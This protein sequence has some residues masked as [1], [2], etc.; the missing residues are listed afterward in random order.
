MPKHDI[1]Q[2]IKKY[3][4]IIIHRHVR[5]D[6]DALGSQC[7]LKAIIQ[8]TF[9]GKRV[10]AVGE[11]DESFHFL[12]RMDDIS[13][14]VYEGALVIVCDTA[15]TGRIS[16]SRYDLGEQLIKIDH[17]PDHDEYG[18]IRWVNTGAS[19]TSEMIYE[20][21]LTGKESGF[22]FNKAAARLIYAG[23]VG[24]TGRFLFPSTKNITF[25]YA[26]DLI[27][28][29]F[30]RQALY[31]DLYRMD[32]NIARLQGY[33]LQHFTMS[34]NGVSTIKLT[35]EI[36][37]RF[38]VDPI[39]TSK[40]VGALGNIN[41]IKSWVYFIEED[42][43]IRVRIRSKGPVINELAAKYRGG[44]HPLASGATVHSW[45]EAEALTAEL[46]EICAQYS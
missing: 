27:E 23:I 33:V 39:E 20:L 24:D 10:Y 28:Y 13:D 25:Q 19:S 45:E 14:D 15:N 4:T 35:K 46:E 22:L 1:I 42:D 11:E 31:D 43:M 36:L 18:D 5:P 26:A 12:A 7:G 6:P 32:E 37:K 3:E 17:H 9:P 8:A 16:D 40:L 21:Y 30:D 41:K 38:N 29:P 34:E 2:T 44:G